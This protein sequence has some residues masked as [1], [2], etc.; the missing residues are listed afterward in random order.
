M[1]TTQLSAMWYIICLLLYG[2]YRYKPT[3]Y[4]LLDS[5]SPDLTVNGCF[6]GPVSSDNLPIQ[7]MDCP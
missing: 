2:E 5:S 4:I 1:L 7:Y 6:D 3:Y